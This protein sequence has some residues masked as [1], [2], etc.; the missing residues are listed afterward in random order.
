[1]AK[2]AIDRVK[3]DKAIAMFEGQELDAAEAL[4]AST[5]LFTYALDRFKKEVPAFRAQLGEERIRD[6]AMEEF[7]DIVYEIQDAVPVAV[8]IFNSLMRNPE[9]PKGVPGG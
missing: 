3:V 1:M 4:L 8:R 7:N 5:R 2:E 9:D 6:F